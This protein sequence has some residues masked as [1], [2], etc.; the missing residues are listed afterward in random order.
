MWS[1]FIW[2]NLCKTKASVWIN[3]MFQKPQIVVKTCIYLFIYLMFFDVHIRIYFRWVN[4]WWSCFIASSVDGVPKNRPI[5]NFSTLLAF[6][7]WIV[8]N[9]WRHITHSIFESINFKLQ[10]YVPFSQSSTDNDFNCGWSLNVYFYD[11]DTNS[12]K[13]SYVIKLNSNLP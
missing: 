12:V 3:R 10:F 4:Y 13:N 8:R 7:V 9:R 5:Q 6:F 1:Y 11:V 2:C